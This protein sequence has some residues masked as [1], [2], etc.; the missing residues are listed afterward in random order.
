MQQHRVCRVE[1]PVPSSSASIF[2][3]LARRAGAVRVENP[4]M[5]AAVFACT[6]TVPST[7]QMDWVA[8][9]GAESIFETLRLILPEVCKIFNGVL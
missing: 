6:V 4:K 9:N 2:R 5:L 1:L 3:N 7:N 8:R